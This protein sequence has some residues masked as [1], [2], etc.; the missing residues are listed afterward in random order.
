[1]NWPK[2]RQ[3][4]KSR[5]DANCD[6]CMA[7]LAEMYEDADAC[8]VLKSVERFE[9]DEDIHEMISFWKNHQRMQNR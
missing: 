6:G 4:R 9:D 2:D 3:W 1:M 8:P 7:G 5:I